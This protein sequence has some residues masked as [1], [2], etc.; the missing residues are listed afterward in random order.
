[1]DPEEL[2]AF[3]SLCLRGSGGSKVQRTRRNTTRQIEK[4]R[5]PLPFIIGAYEARTTWTTCLRRLDFSYSL[6]YSRCYSRLQVAFDF[7]GG[8][9]GLVIVLFP[10]MVS[11]YLLNASWGG[12]AVNN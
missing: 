2:Q 10:V 4:G 9:F 11:L 3:R 5:I 7:G 8:I 12:H 6:V 1:M